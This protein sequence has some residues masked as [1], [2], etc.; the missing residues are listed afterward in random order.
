MPATRTSR[1]GDSFAFEAMDGKQT[2][3]R[4][5]LL[6]PGLPLL[7]CAQGACSIHCKIHEK[8]ISPYTDANALQRRDDTKILCDD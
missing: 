1:V 6:V 2:D 3:N 5:V 4:I 7:S 8:T